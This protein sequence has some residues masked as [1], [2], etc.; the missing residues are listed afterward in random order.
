MERAYIR[1]ASTLEFLAV[2]GYVP[3]AWVPPY[4]AAM[5]TA[6]GAACAEPLRRCVAISNT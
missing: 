3:P 2:T 4:L 5:E 1:L 6:L